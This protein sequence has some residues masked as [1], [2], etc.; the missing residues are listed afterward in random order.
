MS[1]TRDDT[2]PDPLTLVL[3]AT[4]VPDGEEPPGD[5]AASAHP[6]RIRVTRDPRAGTLDNTRAGPRF[7]D[8]VRA[9][10][11]PA[12]GQNAG[13]GSGTTEKASSGGTKTGFTEE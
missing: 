10:W 11:K 6:L 3:R 2:G 9:V 12:E 1:D 5:L 4:F 8:D 7:H 13:G